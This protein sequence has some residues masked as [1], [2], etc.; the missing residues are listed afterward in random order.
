MFATRTI[1]HARRPGPSLLRRIIAALALHRQR[2]RLRDLDPH[3]LK[4]IGLTAAQARAEADTPLWHA[5][6]HWVQHQP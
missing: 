2:Q 6:T 4:D 3:M 1:R 5:P